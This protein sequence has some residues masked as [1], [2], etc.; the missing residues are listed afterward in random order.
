LVGIVSLGGF[1]EKLLMQA[2]GRIE[3]QWGEFV[4]GAVQGVLEHG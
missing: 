3:G 4:D 2:P 1:L